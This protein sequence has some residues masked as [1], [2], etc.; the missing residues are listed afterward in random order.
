MLVSLELLF[1]YS[2]DCESCQRWWSESD[3]YP[4]LGQQVVCNHCDRRSLV[5]GIQVAHPQMSPE[6]F[7]AVAQLLL[8]TADKIECTGQPAPGQSALPR[9]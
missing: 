9:T 3:L 8:E 5:E 6:Q 7:R 1:H 2:C 4:R